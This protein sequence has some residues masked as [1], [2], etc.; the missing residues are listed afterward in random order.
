VSSLELLARA[1]AIVR[2]RG[3]EVRNIDVVV[4]AEQPKLGA[5]LEAMRA[6]VAEAAGVTPADVGLK[7]KTNEGIGPLGRGDAIAVHAVA[8]LARVASS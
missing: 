7:G 5:Y 2:D 3:F 8:Q 1:R 6:R 4:I